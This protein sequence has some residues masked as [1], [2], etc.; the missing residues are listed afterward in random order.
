MIEVASRFQPTA[1]LQFA[2]I[3]LFEARSSADGPG[4]TLKMAHRL[5]S[6]TGARVQLIPGDPATGLAQ[7][8]NTLGQVDL[9][10]ISARLHPQSLAA[11]W[12]SMPRL[13]HA[14]TQVFW[15]SMVPGGG[16]SLRL[17]SP[18]EIGRLAEV[19]RPRQVA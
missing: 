18:S 11:A 1:K 4:V 3:D 12:F 6:G 9:V 10:V 2:G 15:E 7:V 13:L 16:T 17:L 19:A 14:G 5:L 8:A